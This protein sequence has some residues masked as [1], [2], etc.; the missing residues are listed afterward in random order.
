[1]PLVNKVVD[2]SRCDGMKVVHEILSDGSKVFDV[3]IGNVT[4]HAID[5][6]RAYALVEAIDEHIVDLE[7]GIA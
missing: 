6:A 7:G 3:E 5:E 2:W 1:M 4:F